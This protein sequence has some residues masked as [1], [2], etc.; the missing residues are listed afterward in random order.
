MQ[1]SL[2]AGPLGSAGG[3]A[4]YPDNPSPEPQPLDG[5]SPAVVIHPAHRQADGDDFPAPAFWSTR[6]AE[7]LAAA[8]D[9]VPPRPLRER[10]CCPCTRTHLAL[11]L[12]TCIGYSTGAIV[13]VG[14]DFSGHS[15]QDNLRWSAIAG[16]ATAVVT[17]A[18]GWHALRDVDCTLAPPAEARR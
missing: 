5:E 9:A 17:G 8:P 6:T 12:G 15:Q 11:A 16:A 13:L 2:A 10:R 4:A 18:L 3:R 7:A 1:T 14:L